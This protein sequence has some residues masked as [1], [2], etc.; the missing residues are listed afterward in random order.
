MMGLRRCL[1]GLYF[2]WISVTSELQQGSASGSFLFNISVNDEQE[3]T[4]HTLTNFA[5]AKL[6]V[7]ANTL[8]DSAPNRLKK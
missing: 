4:E 7:M 6:W 8:K 5:D 3:V 2:T 1:N